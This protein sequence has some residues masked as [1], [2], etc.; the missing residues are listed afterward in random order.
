M[1]DEIIQNFFVTSNAL[2]CMNETPLQ[3]IIPTLLNLPIKI[4]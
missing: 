1:F 4:L 3:F 2:P